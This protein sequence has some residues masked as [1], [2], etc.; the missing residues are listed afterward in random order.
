MKRWNPQTVALLLALLTILPG[1]SAVTAA[2]QPG[3]KNL[4]LL[5]VGVSRSELVAEFGPPTHSDVKDGKKAEIF[6]FT[7]GYSVA[8]RAGRAVF[9]AAADVFTVYLWELVAT[10][11]EIWLSGDKMAFQVMYDAEDKIEEVVTVEK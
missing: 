2:T 10:P 4:D 9:H 8:T 3:K 6:M 11:I 1:C 5:R 7:Q